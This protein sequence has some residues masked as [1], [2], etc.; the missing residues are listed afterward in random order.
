M[1]VYTENQLM[2]ISRRLWEEGL[3]PRIRLYRVSPDGRKMRVLEEI[4]LESINSGIQ[5]Y[6]LESFGTG[7]YCAKLFSTKY[8]RKILES[9]LDFYAGDIEELEDE[10]YYL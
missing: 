6:A 10:G 1:Y 4:S 5:S 9:R 2:T 7:R 8:G 3:A